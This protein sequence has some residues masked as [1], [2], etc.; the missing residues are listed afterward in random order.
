M[1]GQLS[2]E[3]HISQLYV[4]EKERLEKQLDE[5]KREVERETKDQG[6]Q[7]LPP[8]KPFTKPDAPSGP[9]V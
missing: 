6:S 2:R 3:G 8:S 1:R 5:I 4:Q 9:A 7:G